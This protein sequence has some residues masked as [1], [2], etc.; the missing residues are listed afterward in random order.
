MPAPGAPP[1]G[2]TPLT[3]GAALLTFAFVGPVMPNRKSKSAPAWPRR[4]TVLAALA[5]AAFLAGEGLLLARSDSGR[6]VLARYL[7]LGD[8]ARLTLALSR[9]VR[10]GLTAAGVARDSLREE[11][12]GG[13]APLRWRVGIEPDASLLQVNY[14]ITRAVEERGGV[15]LSGRE[16]HDRSKATVVRL[17]VGLPRRPTHEILLVRPSPRDEVTGRREARLAL[18]LFGFGDDVK[19]A[20]RCFALRAPFAVA[21]VPGGPASAALFRAA[22]RRQ[23]EVVLHLPLEPVNYPQMNPGPGTLLVTMKPA[24]AAKALHRYLG[25]AGPVIAVANHMGSFATQDATLMTAVFRELKRERL[26]FLHVTPA[27]GAVC[28]GLAAE[29]GI[30]YEEPG[31]V[32]DSE[33]RL[34]DPKALERRWDEVLRESRARGRLVVM[35]R[36]TPLSRRWLEDALTP[37]RLEGVSPAPLSALL[38]RPAPL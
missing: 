27:A 34:R 28:K 2:P 12:A 1:R 5:L 4:L 10:R 20:D 32:L 14:A 22:H 30:A 35:V 25:Q 31:A 38:R 19:E 8:R 17:L 16:S 23:R 24:Q 13:T 33:T 26:P 6:I 18:V 36:A 7:G 37:A 3:G 11:V 9:Q 29:L 15:V 21:I